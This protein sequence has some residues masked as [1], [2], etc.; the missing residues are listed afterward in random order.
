MGRDQGTTPEGFKWTRDP[1]MGRTYTFHKARGYYSKHARSWV[2]Q[3]A[4]GSD[5]AYSGTREGWVLA[6]REFC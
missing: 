2:A 6:M 3:K 1:E 4:D 5:C